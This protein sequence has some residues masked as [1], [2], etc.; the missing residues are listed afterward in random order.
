MLR[1]EYPYY[2]GGAARQPNVDLVV[3]DKYS[4]AEATRVALADAAAID[5][6]IEL[7]AGAAASAKT[8]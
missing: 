7:A 2:L 3:Y 6:A 5:R 4:G 8:R 1:P